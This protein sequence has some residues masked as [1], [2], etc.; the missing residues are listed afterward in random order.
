MISGPSTARRS[1][2]SAVCF[3]LLLAM[4][5]ARAGAGAVSPR[6][7][8]EIRDLFSSQTKA[9][10]DH[11]LAALNEMFASGYPGQPDPVSLWP[12]RIVSGVRMPS[13]HIS[14]KPSRE[15]GA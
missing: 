1:I 9:E 8:Q 2:A 11:D 14:K 13:L 3:S 10:T 12:A 4:T 15:R 6:D 5:P 7:M